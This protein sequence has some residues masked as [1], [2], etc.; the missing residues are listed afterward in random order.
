MYMYMHNC[1]YVLYLKYT[2]FTA[3]KSVLTC[4]LRL[5]EHFSLSIFTYH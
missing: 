5:T 2:F 3:N 4:Y 1:S